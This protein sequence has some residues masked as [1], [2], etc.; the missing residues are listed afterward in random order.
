MATKLLAAS[1]ASSTE[2]RLAFDVPVE[3]TSG[4][5]AT[6]TAQTAPAVPISANTWTADGSVIAVTVQPAMTPTA[7]YEVQV[8]GLVDAAGELVAP[9]HD[10]TMF[11]GFAPAGPATRRF[12]LWSMLPGHA[13][14]DDATEDLRRFVACLQEVTD[15]LQTGID[16]WPDIFDVERAPESFVDAI[17]LDLGNPFEFLLDVGA[18]RR[19][20]SSLVQMYRLKGTATGVERAL[21]FFL[22]IETRCVAFNAETLTL[23]ESRL[24]LDWILGPSTRWALY[25][26][27]LEVNRVL[28]DE[29]RRQVRAV[30]N[31]MRPGHTHFVAIVEP[32][33][34]QPDD[35]WVLGVD[36]LGVAL[37][38]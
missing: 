17:L 5:M 1:A 30:V 21:R 12:D 29:E 2:V 34:P 6:F 7:L 27:D 32:S 38:A 19:L 31:L 25:A 36:E 14:R 18:K 28:T 4:A 9:P 24:G 33:A 35:R 11:T 22:A 37:L 23:G 15:L 16:R 10:R 13:R 3:I 8:A 20:A 26:F